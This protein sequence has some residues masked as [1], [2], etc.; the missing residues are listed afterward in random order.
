M[1]N[2]NFHHRSYQLHQQSYVKTDIEGE[3]RL[4]EDWFEKGTVDVWRHLR[5]L[6]NIDPFLQHYPNA[7]WLTIGDGRFGTSAIYINKYG[8]K[9]L[10]TDIDISL[11]KIAKEK[12]WIASYV[13][14]NAEALPFNDNEFDFAFCKEAYH[15]FPRAY[16]GIYE[17]LRIAKKAVILIEPCDWLPSPIPR[18]VL[19]ILKHT[20]KKRLNLPIPHTDTGNYEADGNYIFSIAPREIQKIAL[21]LGLPCV[22]HKTF[23]DVYIKGVEDEKLNS[24]T[25]SF[26]QIKKEITRQKILTNF[27]LSSFNRIAAVLFKETPQDKLLNDIKDIGFTIIHLP[28]NP[29]LSI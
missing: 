26:K 12:H 14:A 1:S 18:R 11:L 2:S 20:I 17:M 15:H 4:Y 7:K 28:Q 19:Q 23:H 6:N 24:N 13:Y 10:P 5:M 21:G 9:P 29:Y 27:G 3:L 25:P 8:G 16:I 22:A